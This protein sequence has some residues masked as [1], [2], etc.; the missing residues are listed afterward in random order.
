MEGLKAVP[1]RHGESQCPVKGGHQRGCVAPLWLLG[2]FR[3]LQNCLQKEQ[4][5]SCCPTVGVPSSAQPTM[6]TQ[7]KRHHTGISSYGGKYRS[8]SA[9]AFSRQSGVKLSGGPSLHICLLGAGPLVH[10]QEI[11]KSVQIC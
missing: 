8:Y 2:E 10:S 9:E 6:L 3:A 11:V 4:P 7:K 5:H 1:R